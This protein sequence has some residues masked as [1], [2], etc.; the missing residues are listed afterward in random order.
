MAFAHL[1]EYKEGTGYQLWQSLL[2]FG[3][4]GAEG[5]GLGNSRQKL[6]YLP[7]AQSDFIF[8]IVGEELGLWGTL[9]VVVAFLALLVIGIL[10]ACKSGDTFGGLLALGITMMLVIQAAINIG[11]VTGALPTKGLSLP[12]ISAGGSNL[13]VTLFEIGVLLS[14]SR[15]PAEALEEMEDSAINQLTP[16]GV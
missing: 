2:A 11:V 4:G 3:D 10:I 5:V 12:F 15:H 13:V 1:E 14:I 9:L 8:A 16:A 6:G 7:E